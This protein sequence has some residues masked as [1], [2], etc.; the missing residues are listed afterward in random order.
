MNWIIK[1][2][3]DPVIAILL[4]VI[5]IMLAWL[6]RTKEDKVASELRDDALN[7]HLED[8]KS[9]LARIEQRVYDLAS[10]KPQMPLDPNIEKRINHKRGE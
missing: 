10:G 9:D 4:V 5:F 1:V 3:P 6:Y 8:Q 7:G 2:V